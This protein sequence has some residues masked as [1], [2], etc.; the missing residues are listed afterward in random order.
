[1]SSEANKA[2]LAGPSMQAA[3][4]AAAEFARKVLR[5]IDLLP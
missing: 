2:A 5:R 3:N 4:P 1:M